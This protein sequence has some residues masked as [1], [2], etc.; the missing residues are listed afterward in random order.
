MYEVAFKVSY[1]KVLWITVSGFK[2]TKF[3]EPAL[4]VLK[5]TF[6]SLGQCLAM[7]CQLSAPAVPGDVAQCGAKCCQ[8]L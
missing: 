6:F 1:F 3:K 5:F 7:A 4:K 8:P 2:E